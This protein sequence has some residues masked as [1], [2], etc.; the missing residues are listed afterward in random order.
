MMTGSFDNLWFPEEASPWFYLTSYCRLPISVRQRYNQLYALGTNEVFAIFES[1][2]ISQI[3]LKKMKSPDF[4]PVFKNVVLSF[5]EE[6][7]KHAEMFHQLNDVADAALYSKSKIALSRKANPVGLFALYLMKKAPD[8]LG[9][10]IWLSFFLEERSLLYSKLYM[11]PKNE[12]LNSAFR[13]AHKLHLLEEN[14]H[15]QLDEV[16]IEAFYKPLSGWKRRLAAWMV[17]VCVKSFMRPRRL[18]L[19]IAN[20]LK[21][22]FP[23]DA[24]V[25]NQCLSELPTLA[26]NKNFHEVTLG[27]SATHRFRTMLAKFPEMKSV[28]ELLSI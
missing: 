23:N 7:I 22:E 1:E 27:V 24:A 9:A 19:S 28:L 20:V 8:W 13:E 10:W 25:I 18:S 6:E 16:L 26:H 14:Y 5:C 12:H 3:L 15:V 2:F 17:G 11:Q 4:D 21:K